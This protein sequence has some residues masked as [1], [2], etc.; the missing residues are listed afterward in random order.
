MLFVI[1]P[2]NSGRLRTLVTPGAVSVCFCEVLCQA[3]S[4]ESLNT[5][6]QMSQ[7]Y[8]LED[9][10]AAAHM[11]LEPVTSATIFALRLD[12]FDL[13]SCDFLKRKAVFLALNAFE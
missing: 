3:R 7:A 6:S 2:L 11:G 13:L 1:Q 8:V 10:F 12:H 9:I 4:V 5:S